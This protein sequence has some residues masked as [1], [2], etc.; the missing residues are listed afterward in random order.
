VDEYKLG[1]G[2]NTPVVGYLPDDRIQLF[3]LVQGQE[4]DSL[5]MY[6]KR[7]MTNTPDSPWS[8]WAGMGPLVY[9]QGAEGLSIGYLPYDGA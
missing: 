3:V 8:D 6:S 7:K 1:G 4:S 9:R 5:M 2:S